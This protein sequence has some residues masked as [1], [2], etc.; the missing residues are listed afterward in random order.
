MLMR[1]KFA[2]INLIIK[3]NFQQ[4]LRHRISNK[5]I[6]HGGPKEKVPWERVGIFLKHPVE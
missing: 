3:I 2:R 5:K 6:S 1:S 4:K